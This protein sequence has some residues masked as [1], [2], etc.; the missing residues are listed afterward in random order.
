MT[1]SVGSGGQG[2][3][4]GKIGTERQAANLVKSGA[5]LAGRR[6][7]L[8]P[9]PR[10][11]NQ[12]AR[13]GNPLAAQH[14]RQ[15]FRSLGA[16]TKA[17]KGGKS[18]KSEKKKKAKKAKGKSLGAVEA[19]GGVKE[20]LKKK[21]RDPR[22]LLAFLSAMLVNRNPKFQ[23][24]EKNLGTFILGIGSL[25]DGIDPKDQAAGVKASRNVT[26]LVKKNFKAQNFIKAD[27]V[28][29]YD[30]L[31]DLLNSKEFEDL[32]SANAKDLLKQAK[33]HS[34]DEVLSD[35]A[36]KAGEIDG[37]ELD[38][39]T[40]QLSE[41]LWEAANKDDISTSID[42]TFDKMC[43]LAD[44]KVKN[45][46][47]SSKPKALRAVY[48]DLMGLLGREARTIQEKDGVITTAPGQA[49]RDITKTSTLK[50]AA[51]DA[52]NIVKA[53]TE[54]HKKQIEQQ[55]NKD[56]GGDAK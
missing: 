23:L 56:R 25:F 5:Q 17:S 12:Q 2:P 55:K 26:S 43:S 36:K 20:E 47:F 53:A 41:S 27:F 44:Q 51:T 10:P 13:H 52:S 28:D 33:K 42:H 29:F 40:V 50:Q 22:E 4:L 16:K 38:K 49:G 14:A 34:Q 54:E 9:H 39:E 15:N 8:P 1:G 32:D 11:G 24:E 37:K 7:S 45:G 35:L 18:E 31:E 30:F 21:Y 3:G 46:E 19:I 48:K 6:G